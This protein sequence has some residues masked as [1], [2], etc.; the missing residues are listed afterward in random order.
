MPAKIPTYQEWLRT[1]PMG[2]IHDYMAEFAINPGGHKSKEQRAWEA[3]ERERK[4]ILKSMRPKAPS[5]RGSILLGKTRIYRPEA[6]SYPLEDLAKDTLRLAKRYG[7][8]ASA[9]EQGFM[10]K[11]A[12]KITPALR[13]IVKGLGGAG[14]RRAAIAKTIALDPAHT[15]YFHRSGPDALDSIMN[16]GLRRVGTSLRDTATPLSS[17]APGASSK[18]LTDAVINNKKL[19]ALKHKGSNTGVLARIPNTYARKATGGASHNF[20]DQADILKADAETLNPKYITNSIDGTNYTLG[21][22]PYRQGF[23]KKLAQMSQA[24]M[25]TRPTPNKMAQGPSNGDPNEAV[26][27]YRKKTKMQKY[28]G[29]K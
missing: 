20:L 14:R 8:Y 22:N 28:L 7:K 2:N 21:S 29:R 26:Q 24:Y 5:K 25:D 11:I 10:T 4:A 15:T 19:L 16:N 13:A 12:L 17:V 1:H 18:A 27:P 9:Y 23:T 6:G 3:E